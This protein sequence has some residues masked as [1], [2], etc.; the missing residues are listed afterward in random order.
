[1]AVI[2]HQYHPLLECMVKPSLALSSCL[3]KK[4][5]SKQK[6]LLWNVGCCVFEQLTMRRRVVFANLATLFFSGDSSLWGKVGNLV[7]LAGVCSYG[8]VACSV[9]GWGPPASDPPTSTRRRLQITG[10]P[11]L[12]LRQHH[13]PG[14]DIERC[15][16]EN[17][18]GGGWVRSF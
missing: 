16:A 15:S 5:I 8:W 9:G 3:A 4:T 2:Y 11:N 12:Q 14:P 10:S 1:M 7:G 13:S 17:E 18:A 6:Q